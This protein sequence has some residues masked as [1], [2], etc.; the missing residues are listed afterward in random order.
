MLSYVYLVTFS[1]KYEISLVQMPKTSL[2]RVTLSGRL[3][4][5]KEGENVVPILIKCMIYMFLDIVI[6]LTV[7][8]LVFYWFVK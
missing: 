1:I 8:V 4:P 3:Q 2:R 7:S 6:V 5:L